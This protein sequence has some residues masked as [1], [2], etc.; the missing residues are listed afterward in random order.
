[1][2]NNNKKNSIGGKN[3]HK[4]IMEAKVKGLYFP[5]FKENIYHWNSISTQN[6]LQDAK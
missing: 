6:I 1:M 5:L 3:Q 2:P 4:K